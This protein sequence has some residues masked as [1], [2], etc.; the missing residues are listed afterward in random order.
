MRNIVLGVCAHVDAG[1]TTLSEAIL[2]KTGAIR[3]LGRVD[4]QDAFLDN[5]QVERE[6]GITVFS[7]QAV[8]AL[9]DKQATLL[10]T[11]GHV[12]FSAEME[13]TL[14]VLDYA[15]LVISG[16]AGVQ[17]HTKTLWQLFKQYKVPTILFVNKMDMP[18][19]DSQQ[20]LEELRSQLSENCV[21]FSMQDEEVFAENV[22]MCDEDA[23]SQFLEEGTVPHDTV[24]DLIAQRK[25]FPCFFG[26]AL[27][28]QGIEEFLKGLETYT[29]AKNYPT[30][31]GARVF[32]IT[33][34]VQ[35]S[36]LT[37]LKVTGGEL[38]VRSL[39]KGQDWEEKINQLRLYSGEKYEL[40]DVAHAGDIVVATGLTQ[41][42]IGEGL[43]SEQGKNV[44]LLEPVLSYRI[45]LDGID[46]L[47]MLPKL[48]ALEEEEP[49]LQIVWEEELKEIH[50]KVMG[51]VQIEILQRIIKERFGVDVEFGD[52]RIVYKETIA[53]TVEGVGHFEPL[54]HYAEVHLLLE[55]GERG[56]GLIFAS[57]VSEDQLERNWQRL[58]L[59]H[60]EERAHRGVLTG[61]V[62]TDMKITLV[63]GRAHQKHTE[64]GDFRQATYRAVRQ[65]LM[66]A[67]SVLLEPFYSYTLEVPEGMIGR[68]M[69]DLERMGC[70][71][72]APQLTR[73]GAVL[74]GQGPVRTM[75]NYQKDLAAYTKG[76]GQLNCQLK[77][78]EPCT[79][80][81]AIIEQ[82]GYDPERDMR[83]PTG[84]V[85][86]AHGA[87]FVVPWYEVPEYMHL[88][89][90]F[91]KSKEEAFEEAALE[92]RRKGELTSV[93]SAIDM[94]LGT[95][96]I[97]QIIERASNA[98]RRQDRSNKWLR[99]KAATVSQYPET[100]SYKPSVKKDAYLLVDGYN[101]I[102][103]WEELKALAETTI[104]GAR[105]RLQDILCN[106][107][108]MKK[109]EVI[110]VFDAYRVKGHDTEILNYHNIHIV[111]TKEAETA[112][113][114]IEKFAH[115]HGSKYD[116]TV[117]TSDGLE[118]IIIRGQGCKLLSA[119]D[120]EAE[121]KAM[122]QTLRA[123]YL[124]RQEKGRNLLGDVLPDDILGDE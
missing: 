87:G 109:C 120:L 15:I 52:G 1:K 17:G 39:M 28:L 107:Q 96:E 62:I 75:K 122:E 53:N 73:G 14:Q 38:A 88:E 7:K 85:F 114:Y 34:D 98:N 46:P 80:S 84:S 103:A 112:D 11:P 60:L 83:N 64:G 115:E 71:F 29:K 12:D 16:S 121:V 90:Y 101:I 106:Y 67:E 76:M 47:Q 70:S 66:Q 3:K 110:L 104:D 4:N 25:V 44:A 119:R 124:E 10:D 58:I 36:R 97:D 94:A 59:T 48:R 69:T 18:D 31:F 40:V 21:D 117:A 89:S 27:K 6:R 9:G 86:C 116:V 68:A 61:S 92:A 91:G 33:R 99:K 43:G 72:G 81:E 30:E 118:Q 13:R 32:K 19:T 100:R 26:S 45:L 2:Y 8:F 55:P 63:A 113:Q 23:L 37:H 82:R 35:G 65:G 54:R 50:V 24:V 20:I 74:S 95:E 79:D 78:Y 102:F 111:Y 57:G 77:G 123:D 49:A 93:V 56:S 42:Q 5:F 41:I 108:G 51:E 105:G 22:A